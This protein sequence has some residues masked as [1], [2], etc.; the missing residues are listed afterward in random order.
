MKVRKRLL[1]WAVFALSLA[2]GAS[3]QVGC[4]E[5]TPSDCEGGDQRVCMCEGNRTGI[6]LCDIAGSWGDCL[7]DGV[8]AGVDATTG[9]D[10][11]LPTDAG[12]DA[13]GPDG[14]VTNP[15]LSSAASHLLISEVATQPGEA[16]FLEIWNPG[17][18][19]VDLSDIH[20]SDSAV[21][22]LI[23]TGAAWSPGGA[24]P[25][26]DFLV[27]FPPGTTLAAGA[28]LVISAGTDFYGSYASCPDFAIGDD[29]SLC[30][31]SA[32]PKMVAPTNGSLGT[33]EGSML[34]NSREMLMLFCWDGSATTVV[35]VDYV[36]W[37]DSYD[38][39]SRVDKTGVAGYAPDTPIANQSY[40]P[41]IVLAN[42]DQS[43]GRC[44]D[45]ETD[46]T[47]TGGNGSTGH[48][49]TSE[50]MATTFTLQ[51]TASPGAVNLCD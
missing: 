46:E 41:A 38:D 18:S 22:H 14:G 49:E 10:G 30:Q 43:I 11:G 6:Q 17:T 50:Q 47:S 12:G 23:S 7:C 2:L 13:G 32:V 21:Y 33:E 42:G 44:N 37:G 4:E 27:R 16:E 5:T 3:L 25:G 40:A 19:P 26:T 24:V 20:V 9:A 8:D 51:G 36:T 15:C 48:D 28:Y 34:S 35:D 45:T 31:G 29:A 1:L 39:L